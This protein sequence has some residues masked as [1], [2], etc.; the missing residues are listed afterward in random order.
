METGE[1]GL[2]RDEVENNKCILID[3]RLA[4]VC[5]LLYSFISVPLGL[6]CQKR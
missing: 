5:K 4:L 6:Q 2:L 1:G 3:R